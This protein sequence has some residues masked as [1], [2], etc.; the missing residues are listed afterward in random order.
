MWRFRAAK[1][2][3]ATVQRPFAKPLLRS[4]PIAWGVIVTF[5]PWYIQLP[6]LIELQSAGAEAYG[7]TICFTAAALYG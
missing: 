6:R 1:Q 2:A 4:F 7:T 5:I 3:L